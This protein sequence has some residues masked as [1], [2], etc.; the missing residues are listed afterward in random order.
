[1]TRVAGAVA[2]GVALY[3]LVGVPR[4]LSDL[5]LKSIG[6]IAIQD[7]WTQEDLGS[8]Y[9]AYEA[10]AAYSTFASLPALQKLVGAG[11]G[12]TVDLGVPVLLA[13]KEYDAVPWIH[14][15]YLYV[16]VKAGVLGLLS[17]MAFFAKMFLGGHP[18]DGPLDPAIVR[19]TVGG[20][21]L[22]NIVV[23]GWFN[24]ESVFAFIVLGY[25][26]AVRVTAPRPDGAGKLAEPA[27]AGGT[28]T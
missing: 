23:C 20:L 13:G 12:L 1:M 2:V 27:F 24:I 3:S 9:R 7:V 16:L 28:P 25:M 14:N 26:F 15:G 5:V 6:E 21:L 10:F 11:F 22:S 18:A 8:R 17:Y 19:G 4:A